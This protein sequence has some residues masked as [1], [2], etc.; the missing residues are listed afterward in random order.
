MNMPKI[1]TLFIF[2]LFTILLRKCKWNSLSV[3]DLS[4]DERFAKYYHCRS[5]RIKTVVINNLNNPKSVWYLR[6]CHLIFPIF[7]AF[8]SV[9]NGAGR[10]QA[11]FMSKL[12]M[13]MLWWFH[14][15]K[16]RCTNTSNVIAHLVL[17]LVKRI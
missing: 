13:F 5:H 1:W 16:N 6:T 2:R 10:N 3:V 7:I 17:L 9:W 14:S 12:R 4:M 11:V 8:W 15:K